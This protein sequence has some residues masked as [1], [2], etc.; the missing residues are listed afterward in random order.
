MEDLEAK[1][2]FVKSLCVTLYPIRSVMYLLNIVDADLHYAVE[3]FCLD[4]GQFIKAEDDIWSAFEPTTKTQKDC[5]DT[6]KGRVTWLNIQ[7]VKH[8][9]TSQKQKFSENFGKSGETA[10][11]NVHNIYEEIGMKEHY[12]KYEEEFYNKMWSEHIERLP[13]YLPKQL[14]IDLLDY[15][16][17]KKFRG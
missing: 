1:Q 7:V 13:K 8:G 16:L 11:R 15:A 2:Q 14:F 3:Q 9:T 4:L 17:I 10:A 6:N 12:K 5:T